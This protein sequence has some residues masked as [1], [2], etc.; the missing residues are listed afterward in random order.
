MDS[1]PQFKITSWEMTGGGRVGEAR[2]GEG[3]TTTGGSCCR[4]SLPPSICTQCTYSMQD[5][6]KEGPEEAEEDCCSDFP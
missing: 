6:N 2:E 5:I 4:S 1:H 3:E